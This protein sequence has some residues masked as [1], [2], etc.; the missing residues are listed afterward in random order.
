[1]SIPL[2]AFFDTFDNGV[3]RAAFNNIT[4]NMPKVPTL[5]SALSL[6]QN[7]LNDRAYGP[8]ATIVPY[9]QVVELF[10]INWDAGNHPL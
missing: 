10:V 1:M 3:N 6:G 8:S 7:A 4:Y 9:N 2:N 5:L